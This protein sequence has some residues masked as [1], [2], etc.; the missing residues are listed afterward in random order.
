VSNYNKNQLG[1]MANIFDNSGQVFLASVALQ[2]FR[3]D[4]ILSA[5]G[6]AVAITLW[7][8]SF[9]VEKHSL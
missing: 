8:V 5:I 2:Y 4:A 6:F 3:Q 1:R 9:W 7:T